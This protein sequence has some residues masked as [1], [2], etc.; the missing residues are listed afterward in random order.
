[1]QRR[2]GSIAGLIISLLG[3]AVSAWGTW[4]LAESAAFLT[5]AT[6]T[7]TGHEVRHGS[8]SGRSHYLR[9]RDATGERL[10]RVPQSV[11]DGCGVGEAFTRRALS[12]EAGC[13]R[14]RDSEYSALG[15]VLLVPL[16]GLLAVGF[17]VHAKRLL[18]DRRRES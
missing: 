5:G 8:K 1:M 16:V 18:F 13:P 4:Q 15:L 6:G 2:K 3:G 9:I 10:V 17:V 12:L 7:I 11:H 14:R